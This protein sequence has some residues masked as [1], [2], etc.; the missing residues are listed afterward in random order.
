MLGMNTRNRLAAIALFAALLLAACGGGED[1]PATTCTHT[2]SL[3][4]NGVCVEPVS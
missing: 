4:A 3:N 2:Q 1:D